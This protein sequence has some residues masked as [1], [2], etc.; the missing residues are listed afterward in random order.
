MDSIKAAMGLSHYIGVR[1]HLSILINNIRLD[2]ILAKVN[3]NFLGLIPSWLD[4]YDEDDASSMKEKQYVLEKTKLS[5]KPYILPIMLCPSDFDF[6]CTVIVVEVICSGKNV[7]WNKFGIDTTPFDR[8]ETQLPKYI[9][10]EV[11][12][13]SE[14][15]PFTFSKDEYLHCLSEFGISG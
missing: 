4:Y 12:W 13:F 2:E 10:K 15:G 6:S 3:E 11:T 7:I 1:D 9:G 14:I 5:D 8:Y